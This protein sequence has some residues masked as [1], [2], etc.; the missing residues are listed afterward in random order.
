MIG[1]I[2]L[3]LVWLKNQK[4]GINYT[5][6]VNAIR[7]AVALLVIGIGVIALMMPT[8]IPTKVVAGVASVFSLYQGGKSLVCILQIVR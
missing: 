8:I 2:V 4:K 6:K 3:F 5:L 7:F 1:S